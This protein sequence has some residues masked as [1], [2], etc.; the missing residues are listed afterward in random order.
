M[1]RQ[2]LHSDAAPKALGPYSQAVAVPPGRLVFL[3][4]QVPI[5]PATGELIQGDVV[6]Q[7]E[8]VMNNLSAV[9]KAGGLTFEQVV[10]CT[11]Y[12]TDLGDFTKVNEVYGKRFPKD[13]PARVTVQVSALPKG[14]KVEIDAI[15]VSNS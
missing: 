15:A 10:R 3:S 7:T 1:A 2:I 13:P 12:L 9:L 14:A 11:I 5:V 8:Q 6:Q 4:G